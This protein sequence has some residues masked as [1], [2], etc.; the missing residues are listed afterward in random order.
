MGQNVTHELAGRES[1][2]EGNASMAG[3]DSTES[4]FRESHRGE[5]GQGGSHAEEG[6]TPGRCVT[7]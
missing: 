2:Y 1:R 3:R 4:G 5:S 7:E 6:V